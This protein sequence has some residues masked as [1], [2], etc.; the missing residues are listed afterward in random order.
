[1]PHLSLPCGRVLNP[2]PKPEI[3]TI[4]IRDVTALQCSEPLR[5][6]VGG[7]IKGLARFMTE[8]IVFSMSLTALLH[9]VTI[10]IFGCIILLFF[11]YSKKCHCYIHNQMQ[12]HNE[13]CKNDRITNNLKKLIIYSRLQNRSYE[14][15]YNSQ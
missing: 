10:E 9:T 7:P 3:P 13:H 6:K 1:M 15:T 2:I 4:G 5:Y 14:N 11:Y 12:V 8:R